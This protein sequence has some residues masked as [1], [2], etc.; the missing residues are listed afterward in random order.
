MSN[1]DTDI[2]KIEILIEIMKKNDL[3]EVEIKHG[4]DKI[5]LKRS[6]P[7]Q[8]VPAVPV[9]SHLNA[10]AHPAAPQAA[11]PGQ[12]VPPSEADEGLVDIT[13]PMVG[14]FYAQPSPDAEPFVEIGSSVDPQSVVCII[15]AMK[16]MNEIKA[17][18][19]GTIERIMVKNGQAVEFG[20]VLFKIRPE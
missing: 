6:G 9:I 15:E 1:K 10:A 11:A 19:P 5:L 13:S 3:M 7:A 14:T 4:D 12:L 20:Q 18:N 17:E 8:P 2:S 16:V